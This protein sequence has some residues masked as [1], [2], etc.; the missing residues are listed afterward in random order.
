MDHNS[1]EDT[2]ISESEIEDYVDVSYEKLKKGKLN[3]KIS[4]H[5]FS[6]PFCSK[7]RKR[8]FQYKDLLQ[9]ASAVGKG[10]SQKRNAREKANHLALIKYLEKDL[11]DTGGSSQPKADADP[12]IDCNQNEM[13]V[14]PWTGIVVN[15]P[16][17]WKDGRYVGQS[18]SNLRDQ[19]TRRG[20]NPIRVHPLWNYRGHSGSAV[21]EFHKDWPG[22]HN[23]MS[24][25]KAYE[26][27]HHG[28][29]DWYAS[30]KQG[31]GLYAWVARTDD[32]NS[33]GI[34]GEHLRKT[35]DL[36]TISDMMAEEARKQSKL[37]SNL[38]N[39]IEV[40]NQHLKE[41]ESR[42]NETSLSLNNLI[43]EKDK[44]HQSYNEEIR[45]IQVSAREH[46][47][48]IFSE[49]QKFKAQL[50]SHK[51]E[52]ESRKE[53]LE[54]RESFNESESKKLS[55]E[56]EK[57]AM[58][59]SSVQLASL[60]QQ[61][62]D[63][64]VLKLAEDQERQ[65]ENLHKRIIQLE[66][67]LDTKQALELEI[68]GLKGKLNVMKHMGDDGDKEVLKKMESLLAVLREKEGEL[69][70]LEAL[71]QTLIVKE[72]KSNDELQDARKELINYLKDASGRAHIG[73]RRMGELDSKPFSEACKRKYNADEADA[74]A[75]ELE[76][77]W[78]EYLKDPDWHPF[79][80]IEVDGKHEEV[81]D[82]QDE[83]LSSLKNDVGEE[84]YEAV[85]RA[86]KEINEYN[87]SGRYTITELWN[88]NEGKKAT[89]KEAVAFILRKWKAQKRKR[90]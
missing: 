32:Y 73:V 57:N 75:S 62:A 11:V 52:L 61:R 22:L 9:H 53:E 44:L 2:D 55:E 66:K 14:W 78:Q 6:C 24:F 70:D 18:G 77:L 39:V 38:T 12:P 49:H 50:E 60:E 85:T 30:N 40:K 21:V 1:E 90:G 72:R 20:F 16:T 4:D 59:N 76:S 56:I 36:R 68:E 67:Q 13:L 45:K 33:T 26:A 29:K 63:E 43:E 89:L 74:R 46:L 64:N 3:V 15:L 83:K 65:K 42:F 82:D 35:G 34:I 86:L 25:E 69:D 7:K 80:V 54:K 88:F 71:N 28:K 8:D 17:E 19:L 81:I 47:Q 58:Q 10:S 41:M 84:V 48:K 37:V 23:A 79:R 27:D 87:P 51:K 31:S 5:T